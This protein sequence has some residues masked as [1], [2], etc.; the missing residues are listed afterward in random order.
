MC[1]NNFKLLRVTNRGTNVFTEKADVKFSVNIPSELRIPNTR[2]KVSV[3]DGIITATT[4][5]TFKTIRELGIK[6]NLCLMSNSYD[7]E[8]EN[9]Y[10]AQQMAQLF[11]CNLQQYHTN[12]AIVSFHT[13]SNDEFILSQL[14]EKLTFERYANIAGVSQEYAIDDYIQFTLKLEYI[15]L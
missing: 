5:A 12:N 6:C 10:I 11:N 3:V 1:N 15:D 14:P 9:S 13:S 8:V 4:D 2:V 7:T